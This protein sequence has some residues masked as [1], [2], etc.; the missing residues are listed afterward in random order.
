MPSYSFGYSPHGKG[1]LPRS[2]VAVELVGVAGFEPAA[3][4]S[5]TKRAA[6]LR[7]TPPAISGAWTPGA[8]DF[9]GTSGSL[10]DPRHQREQRG[11]RTTGEPGRGPG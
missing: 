3:S 8:A 4:S 11:F 10:A 7:H 2:Q 6:K 9:P 1:H 5:R